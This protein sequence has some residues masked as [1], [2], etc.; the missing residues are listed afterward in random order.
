MR[1]GLIYATEDYVDIKNRYTR[2]VLDTITHDGKVWA[3]P[4]ESA[5]SLFWLNDM[6]FKKYGFLNPSTW[7]DI[8]VIRNKLKG[9]RTVP[10]V[11]PSAQMWLITM[12][13][14]LTLP[15]FSN[16]DPIG[17]TM[18]IMK[19][20][21]GYDH[22]NYIMA[23]KRIESLAKEGIIITGSA[24]IY[25]DEPIQLF[26]QGKAAMFYMGNW[27]LPTVKSAVSEGA[28]LPPTGSHMIQV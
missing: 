27:A 25:Y 23:Y 5:V 8:K 9:S 12:L 21:V 19:D 15:D 2:R 14:Y 3:V 24:G 20:E 1:N 13:L 6:V 7:N 11:Y 16:N 18:K 10:I 17:L 22:T 26:V 4:W 28:R